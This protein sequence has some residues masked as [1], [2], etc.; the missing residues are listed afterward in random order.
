M[1][2]TAKT[3]FIVVVGLCNEAIYISA[4]STLSSTRVSIVT[5]IG[6]AIFLL[7]PPFGPGISNATS[8]HVIASVADRKSY[9]ATILYVFHVLCDSPWVSQDSKF[10]NSALLSPRIII[11][12]IIILTVV[13]TNV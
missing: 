1:F 11:S 7:L 4:H 8:K 2:S 9:G 13:G 10:G 12:L 5:A 3:V 6:C